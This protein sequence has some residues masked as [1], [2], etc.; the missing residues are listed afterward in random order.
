[1]QLVLLACVA[2]GLIL[3]MV[4]LFI[5][6]NSS[7]LP[8]KKIQVEPVERKAGIDKSKKASMPK[9]FTVESKEGLVCWHA[10][11]TVNDADMEYLDGKK[12]EALIFDVKDSIVTDEGLKHI[13]DLP[14]RYLDLS[15]THVGDGA[16]VYVGKLKKIDTL[17]LSKLNITNKGLESL[18][19][20]LTL[21]VLEVSG[22]QPLNDGAVDF[23]S[24]NFPNMQDLDIGDCGITKKCFKY[25][26]RLPR[27][28]TLTITTMNLQD[29]DLEPIYKLRLS[30]LDLACNKLTDKIMPRFKDMKR[31]TYLEVT[32]NLAITEDA[33]IE[34]QRSRPRLKIARTTKPETADLDASAIL[35]MQEEGDKAGP[36]SGDTLSY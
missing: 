30:S 26:F 35:E 25:L 10:D 19:D 22:C 4:P 24:K 28:N 7:K 12:V 13:V 17:I 3:G 21:K 29:E 14:I 33:C 27:L 16:L 6:W 23:I 32:H 36:S 18:K 5:A 31:L 2:V 34:L 15:Q 8:E 9:G 20:L 11:A 1:M